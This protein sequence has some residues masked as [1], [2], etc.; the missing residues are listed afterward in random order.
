MALSGK[1]IWLLFSFAHA[2]AHAATYFVDRAI[3]NDSRTNAQAQ[4]QLTPWFSI[5]KCASASPP[6]QPG[7]VCLVKPTGIYS[8]PITFNVSGTAAAPITYKAFSGRP[9]IDLNPGGTGANGGFERLH[10]YKAGYIVWEGF[11]V[12][13]GY[14]CFRFDY[15][16]H[17]AIR[18]NI[19]HDTW[20]AWIGG[21]GIHI[22]IDRNFMYRT[23]LSGTSGHGLYIVGSNYTIT[24]NV[25]FDTGTGINR[26]YII[27]AAAY[28][29][30]AD[31]VPRGI[32][33]EY[34]G[35]WDSYIANNVVAY[36][37]G[38]GMVLWNAGNG[39]GITEAGC[40][41]GNMRGN[42]VENNIFFENNSG[43]DCLDCPSTTDMIVRNN[44]FYATAP[45]GTQFL[46]GSLSEMIESGTKH[47]DPL[48]VNAPAGQDD[49]PSSPDFRLRP[50][51]PAE[52][53]GN[54]LSS[55]LRAR[56]GMPALILDQAGNL[57]P[58][59]GAGA[60]ERGAYE[61]GAAAANSGPPAAPEGFK[62]R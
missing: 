46:L 20:T 14:D 60:W 36:G 27:H 59:S 44:L 39:S 35:F 42:I 30:C 3:G 43:L 31:R 2:P 13:D 10:F 62:F 56:Y 55:E 52:N 57:R 25:F 34:G 49:A 61:A 19:C 48:F 12:R 40:V 37:S 41:P 7:D 23:A 6:L 47:A 15:A 4:S 58:A 21:G 8:E 1:C 22:T 29:F 28:Q 53:G 24:N 38:G 16:H 33:P 9:V 11:E 5:R 51:S 17:I 45:R 54:N 50:G 26:K 18:D 32:G